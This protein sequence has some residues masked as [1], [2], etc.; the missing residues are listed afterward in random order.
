MKTRTTAKSIRIKAAAAIMTLASVS[1]MLAFPGAAPGALGKFAD[2]ISITADAASDSNVVIK[3]GSRMTVNNKYY[4]P[5]KQY[6]VV[7]QGDGNLVLYTSA[8][9]A[10]W[11]TQTYN[12]SGA[13]A[14]LQ[15]D[16]N[17]VV[18]NKDAKALWHAHTHTRGAGCT[19]NI[20][21]DGSIYVTG[22]NGQKYWT[23][24]TQ[25][26]TAGVGSEGRISALKA[27]DI[28]SSP[29][30]QYWAVLQG[31]G[32]FV[33]Y[34]FNDK[35]IFAS[36]TCDKIY[37]EQFV[38]QG[39]GNLVMYNQY[40]A[41]CCTGVKGSG[42]YRVT[43]DNSG[44][45]NVINNANGVTVW[46]SRYSKMSLI[47]QNKN[48]NN[49][50]NNNGNNNGNNSGNINDGKDN[51]KNQN[52]IWPCPGYNYISSYYGWRTWSDGS[53]EFHKG[54]DIGNWN[55]YGAEVVAMKDG[56]LH[57]ECSTCNQDYGKSTSCPCGH[58]GN[59]G[60]HVRIEHA[61]GTTTRYAHLSWVDTSLD[62]QLV[63]QGKVIGKVGTTGWSTGAH[64]HFEIRTGSS[65]SAPTVNPM[66]YF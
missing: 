54:I 55:I 17:F 11:N 31:D 48:N 36:N 37:P 6:Y 63:K 21:N 22:K 41:R 60:N 53:S 20:S 10:I 52:Y 7:M 26:T 58:C 15:N 30:A 14:Q 38:I 56:V 39:D 47:T 62:G 57:V 23:S 51:S 24:R 32:N 33:V 27:G 28:I 44:Y 43:L 9:K 13:F 4:S 49:N 2:S 45:I 40:G 25:L 8:G 18:Y 66:Q 50:N 34:S 12:N 1:G 61:D 59:Y 3:A 16:G 29:N 5:N 65:Y 42:S 64:L 19:L 46:S 35:V